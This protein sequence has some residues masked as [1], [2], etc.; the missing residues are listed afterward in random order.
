MSENQENETFSENRGNW[1][2]RDAPCEF[3]GNPGGRAPGAARRRGRGLSHRTSGK[4][5]KRRRYTTRAV[6]KASSEPGLDWL[7]VPE[8]SPGPGEVLVGV[9]YAAIC[10]TDL[11]ILEWDAWSR[12]QLQPPRVVGHE[13]SGEVQALGEGVTDLRVGDR[14][15]A[16]THI[17]CG[18]CVQCLTGDQHLCYNTHL[19]GVHRDGAFAKYAVLPRV[20]AWKLA[21]DIPD[22]VGALMEPM[23]VAI[24]GLLVEEVA[25]RSVAIF[26]AGPIG[27][28]AAAIARACGAGPIFAVDPIPER[29]TLALEMGAT[30]VL[31]SLSSDV[32]GAILEETRGVGTDIVLELTGNPCAYGPAFQALRKGGRISLV[33][34]VSGP[35]TLDVNSALVFKGAR[36][37][38][39]SGRRMFE[40]WNTMTSLLERGTLN[41]S[42]LISHRLPLENFREGF[43]LAKEGRVGKVLL[44]P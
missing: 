17:P 6:V 43:R 39:I 12:S 3:S 13:F 8:P 41:P 36:C 35:V 11:H 7:E 15:C 18:R 4:G 29:R 26:G 21:D 25:G 2:E 24:H 32:V 10:G 9:R 19:F 28:M 1:P 14:V 20:C 16:E 37:Y 34:V 5:V 40:T 44:L 42:T 38:G 27:I 33:G 31:D 22:E 30:R 23:G